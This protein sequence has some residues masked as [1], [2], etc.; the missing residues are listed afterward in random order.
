MALC[1]AWTGPC[2]M[3]SSHTLIF[4]RIFRQVSTV[5]SVAFVDKT[6]DISKVLLQD[7]ILRPTQ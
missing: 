6:N 4:A 7:S 3:V 5:V 2:G 1:K